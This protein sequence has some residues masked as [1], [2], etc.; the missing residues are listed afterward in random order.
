[1]VANLPEAEVVAL[2]D[3][4]TTHLGSTLK[5]LQEINPGTKART[6]TDFREV[7]EQNDIDAITC[8]TPDHWHAQVAMLAFEAGKDVYGEKPLS[9]DVKEGQE[10]LKRLERHQRVFQLGTQIHAGEN[11]HRVIDILKAGEIGKIHTVRL[12]KNGFSPVQQAPPNAIVPSSLDWDMWLGPAPLVSYE[13]SRCH[14]SYRYFLDYSG[15]VFADFWCHI[16]DIVW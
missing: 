13:P 12:W 9:Y 4:D 10:M 11:Y 16:A 1:M 7:L 3:V 6:Y 5:K 14:R 2:C 15:G 8:A